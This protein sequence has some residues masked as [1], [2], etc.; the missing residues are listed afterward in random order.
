MNQFELAVK[1]S[2]AGIPNV[3][4]DKEYKKFGREIKI[5]INNTYLVEG[6]GIAEE[7]NN[8]MLLFSTIRKNLFNTH[9]KN[10]AYTMSISFLV[11]DNKFYI[12]EAIAL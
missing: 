5:L 2:I 9:F 8:C 3:L 12:T 10:Q 6:S 7:E 4:F 11:K 1:Q